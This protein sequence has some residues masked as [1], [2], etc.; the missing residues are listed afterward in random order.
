MKN[1]AAKVGMFDLPVKATGQF[2]SFLPDFGFHPTLKPTR[3]HRIS[4]IIKYHFRG[5]P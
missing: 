3:Q 1:E 4:S 2:L 5:M